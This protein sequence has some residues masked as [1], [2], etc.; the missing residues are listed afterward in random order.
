[1][2]G[3]PPAAS[4]AFGAAHRGGV[5]ASNKA[6]VD[7]LRKNMEIIKGTVSADLGYFG[8]RFIAEK[9][10]DQTIFTEIRSMYGVGNREKA[11]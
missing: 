7:V 1:M 8:S 6:K 3:Q 4:Q 9:L 2:S 11:E 5:A 10:V